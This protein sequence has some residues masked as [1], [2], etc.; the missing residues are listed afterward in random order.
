[1]NK[2]PNLIWNSESGK[3]NGVQHTTHFSKLAI[4]FEADDKP[5]VILGINGYQFSCNSVESAKSE[6]ED[7]IANNR[8]VYLSY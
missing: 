2:T 1:M 6:A 3:T 8:G 7:R 4:I 5:G